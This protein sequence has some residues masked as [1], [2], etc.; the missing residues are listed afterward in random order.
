[1]TISTF[2]RDFVKRL[3]VKEIAKMAGVS[4][5]AVSFVL[6]NR[7][8][9]SEATREKVQKIIKETGFRPNLSS[10]KLVEGKSYNICLMMSK[11][12]SP[13]DD[14]FYYEIMRGLLEASRKSAY[15][16]IISRASKH[17]NELPDVV[18]SGDVD[19]IIYLQNIS[20]DL[21]EKT[22]AT[23]VPFIVI[24]SH[25]GNE[26]T[27]SITPDYRRATANAA[28]YL[29]RKGHRRIAMLSTDTV[30]DFHTATCEGFAA[31]MDEN[32]VTPSY[33]NVIV[34][35]ESEA[36]AA[37]FALLDSDNP[38]DALLC[39]VDMFAIGAMRAAKDMGL[40]V[41]KD[42]S[43]IGI[44]DILLS[45]YVEPPLTTVGIDKAG[46]GELAMEMLLK[47]INGEDVESVLLPMELIERESVR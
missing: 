41:P 37:A 36:Y 46:I 27:T 2:R 24:D 7:P 3:T 22:V 25:S 8:G 4:V 31:A 42:I 40:S 30:P 35:N 21:A 39:T 12:R 10:K 14:L 5:T 23:G 34:K 1:M 15:N 11:G 33:E 20:E 45:R 9:V 19:G 16:I 6:N 26:H 44:D 43:L 47:K 38:P 18:Y 28:E 13:F 17:G 29:I 32:A